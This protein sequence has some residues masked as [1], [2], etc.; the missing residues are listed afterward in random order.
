MA[1]EISRFDQADKNFV[2]I[3]KRAHQT[4]N[5]LQSCY[6]TGEFAKGGKSVLFRSL[7]EDFEACAKALVKYLAEKRKAFPRL[8]F[9][10]DLELLE[11]LSETNSIEYVKPYLK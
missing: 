5:V 11:L 3:M 7:L 1:T 10:D 2:K 8:F 6:G 4:P 9:L